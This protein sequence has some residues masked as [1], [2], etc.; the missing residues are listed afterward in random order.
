MTPDI[1]DTV[2]WSNG[3]TIGELHDL[4]IKVGQDMFTKHGE[5]PA[6]WLVVNPT[7]DSVAIIVTPWSNNHEKRAAVDTMHA[8]LTGQLD[9]DEKR[10]CPAYAFFCEAYMAT[11][12]IGERDKLHRDLSKE[13]TAEDIFMVNSCTME[14]EMLF[15]RFGVVKQPNGKGYLKERDDWDVSDPKT[16]DKLQGLLFNVYEYESL[17]TPSHEKPVTCPHCHAKQDMAQILGR[18][19]DAPSDGDVCL[20]FQC[21]EA[22]IFDNKAPYGARKAKTKE[23]ADIAKDPKIAMA[24]A[25]IKA[26]R[27]IKVDGGSVRVSGIDGLGGTGPRFKGPTTDMIY[28]NPERVGTSALD[29]GEIMQIGEAM[30]AVIRKLKK[31]RITMGRGIL[32]VETVAFVEV[33]TGP[34][35]SNITI[36]STIP[37]DKART[38]CRDFIDGKI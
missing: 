10:H 15:S 28:A 36:A 17:T 1:I 24:S 18:S 19:K 11:A 3:R 37:L 31:D 16:P 8:L 23:Q 38:I 20:C 35:S 12:P 5:A 27:A 33:R 32:E 26:I 14:G 21:G 13:P 4:A 22:S 7:A 29:Q 34:K 30:A 9:P 2:E 6:T 25:A